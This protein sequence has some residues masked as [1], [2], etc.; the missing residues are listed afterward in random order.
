MVLARFQRLTR[1]PGRTVFSTAVLILAACGPVRAD[2]PEG[3]APHAGNTFRDCPDCPEMVVIPAGNFLMGSST[4][5]TERELATVPRPPRGFSL[6]KL[7]G[8]TDAARARKF[9]AHEHPQHR[10]TITN[11]FAL[12]K[13]LVT[14]GEFSA[15]VRETGYNTGSCMITSGAHIS[16]SFGAA[17]QDP[18]FSQTVRNP[19]VCVNWNDANAYVDWLNKKIGSDDSKNS[20]GPYRLPSEAEWEYAARAGTQTARWWGDEIGPPNTYCNGCGDPPVPPPTIVNGRLIYPPC[21][22]SYRRQT[23]PVGSY[24]ANPFGLFDMMGNAWDWTE[25]CWHDN[26]KDAPSDGGPWTGQNCA[27]RVTRG[28]DWNGGNAWSVRSATRTGFDPSTAANFIGFRVV[29]VLH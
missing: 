24:P 12:G 2:S 26:Y 18:G 11:S 17:W 9:L 28:G 23:T 3:R 20:D 27:K 4:T 22:G 14:A 10:V 1:V 13:Y 7:L 5:D 19:V 6:D 8:I 21:C 29:K 15:F 16:H 25:D